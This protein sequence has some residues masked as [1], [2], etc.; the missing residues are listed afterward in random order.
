MSD[1]LKEKGI[2]AEHI[3]SDNT[4]IRIIWDKRQK[5]V[6]DHYEEYLSPRVKYLGA[7][8]TDF[9]YGYKDFYERAENLVMA[10]VKMSKHTEIVT[11]EEVFR[12]IFKGWEIRNVDEDGN[13]KIKKL[14]EKWTLGIDGYTIKVLFGAW[15]GFAAED[16]YLKYPNPKTKIGRNFNLSKYYLVLIG[17][18][19]FVDS[20]TGRLTPIQAS[21]LWNKDGLSGDEKKKRID[22][23]MGR[24]KKKFDPTYRDIT[25][26]WEKTTDIKT[27]I[28]SDELSGR[29]VPDTI[30]ET[31]TETIPEGKRDEVKVELK[32]E[33][34]KEDLL[35]KIAR[36]KRIKTGEANVAD[37]WE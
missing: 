24:I 1:E 5:W 4:K 30:I 3:F 10:L 34:N 14:M 11:R 27:D 9:K 37:Y 13:D 17:D 29:L 26:I 23:L 36:K 15:Y 8:G 6:I 20:E 35:D 25:N 18:K 31:T 2:I 19:E 28:G 7:D 16:E 21:V 22:T 32:E 12:L 33:T